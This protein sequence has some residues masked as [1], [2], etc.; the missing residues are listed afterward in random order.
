LKRLVVLLG[1]PGS[2]KTTLAQTL[3][4]RGYKRINADDIRHE[5]W[6]DA[7]DQSNPEKV[8][9][10]FNARYEEML[11]AGDDIVVDNTNINPKH[12]APILTKARQAG[13]QDIQLWVLDVPLELCLQGNKARGRN[14][15]E[16]VVANYHDF[17]QGAGRPKRHEGHIIIVRRGDKD[18]QWK[19]FNVK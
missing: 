9:A 18:F 1:I 2:G 13:Y 19:F 3:A 4:E 7:I 14:V 16:E 5:L 8:F 12:R 10:I 15:P 17:L 6:G 11:G